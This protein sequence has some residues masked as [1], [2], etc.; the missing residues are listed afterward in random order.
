MWTPVCDVRATTPA[1]DVE[2]IYRAGADEVVFGPLPVGA[3]A[4]PVDPAAIGGWAI[5]AALAFGVGLLI[6]DPAARAFVLVAL[7]AITVVGR[8]LFTSRPARRPTP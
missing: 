4:T 5:F 6:D 2:G 7:A 1:G 3:T 8:P